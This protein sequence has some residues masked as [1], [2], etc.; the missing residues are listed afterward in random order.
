MT[1]SI[2]P[3]SVVASAVSECLVLNTEKYSKE[4]ERHANSDVRTGLKECVVRYFVIKIQV[5]SA[6]QLIFFS[7]FYFLMVYIILR[8]LSSV[9]SCGVVLCGVMSCNM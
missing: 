8:I 4:L 2:V 3:A 9:M 5:C 7:K 1:A 6:L